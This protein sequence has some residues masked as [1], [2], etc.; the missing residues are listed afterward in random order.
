[1]QEYSISISF[2]EYIHSLSR[3]RL[4][5]L[6]FSTT[7]HR[8]SKR[9]YSTAKEEAINQEFWKQCVNLNI[10][11]EKYGICISD[12]SMGMDIR[13]YGMDEKIAGESLKTDMEFYGDY[14]KKDRKRLF[15]SLPSVVLSHLLRFGVYMILIMAVMKGTVSVGSI[16]KYVACIMLL[17]DAV[18]GLVSTFQRVF[19]NNYYLKRFFSYFDIKNSMYQG[20]KKE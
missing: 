7:L 20:R 17:L 18:S 9:F 4:A 15:L 19:A 5:I 11:A 12:Y 3:Y 16:A 6:I 8:V 10:L 2:L 1:M 14:I 13:L